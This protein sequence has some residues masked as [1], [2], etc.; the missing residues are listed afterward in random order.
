L[1]KKEEEVEE[2][3]IMTKSFNTTNVQGALNV[4]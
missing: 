3:N 4:V 2:D 1:K